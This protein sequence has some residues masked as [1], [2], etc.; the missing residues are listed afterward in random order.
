MEGDKA[1]VHVLGS[2]GPSFGDPVFACVCRQVVESETHNISEITPAGTITTSSTCKTYGTYGTTFSPF[3][4]DVPI[5]L[6]G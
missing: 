6:L 1:G 3:S 2:G 5:T 4:A